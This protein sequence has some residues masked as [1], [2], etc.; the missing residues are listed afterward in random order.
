[1]ATPE[2]ERGPFARFDSS[3]RR[4][5][6]VGAFV[7]VAVAV[8][9]PFVADATARPLAAFVLPCLVTAVLGGWRP[10]LLVGITSF[11]VPPVIGLLGP[12][13][14]EALLARWLIIGVGVL[15]GSR[16]RGGS[17][18]SIGAARRSQ[19]DDDV[20]GGLRARPGASADHPRRL[21]GRRPLSAGRIAHST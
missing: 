11:S 4:A 10:T 8:A 16:R 19:R 9:Y 17:P 18:A 3:D 20:A 2:E 12:L 15:D 21:R 14:I 6:I 7:L 13:D 5:I 1:M